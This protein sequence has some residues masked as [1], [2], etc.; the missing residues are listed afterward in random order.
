MV[1][2]RF[3]FFALGIF[4]PAMDLQAM[5]PAPQISSKEVAYWTAGGLGSLILGRISGKIAKGQKLSPQDQEAL[6]R[7][8][9]VANFIIGRR[10]RLQEIRLQQARELQLARL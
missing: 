8:N 6:K 7:A 9:L 5:A 10:L 2:L 4:A 1:K 3:L